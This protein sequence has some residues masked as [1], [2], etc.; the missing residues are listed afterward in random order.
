M[1]TIDEQSILVLDGQV[2]I[3]NCNNTALV[4]FNNSEIKGNDL[5]IKN[6][7]GNAINFDNSSDCFINV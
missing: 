3:E 5:I 6:I 1:S 4:A 2:S 7:E